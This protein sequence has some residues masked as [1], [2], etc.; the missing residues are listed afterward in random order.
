[1]YRSYKHSNARIVLSRFAMLSSLVVGLLAPVA[2]G[3]DAP[4]T[5]LSNDVIR[6]AAL[7]SIRN[8]Q[9]ALMDYR[10]IPEIPFFPYS[11]TFHTENNWTNYFDVILPQPGDAAPG[12]DANNGGLSGASVM[13]PSGKLLSLNGKAQP[14]DIVVFDRDRSQNTDP[15]FVL[16]YTG[17]EKF[18]D[19]DSRTASF[20]IYPYLTRLE[21][22]TFPPRYHRQLVEKVAQTKFPDMSSDQISALPTFV[23][24]RVPDA[25]GDQGTW[26]WLRKR[27]GD[28]PHGF[29]PSRAWRD[30]AYVVVRAKGAATVEGATGLTTALAKQTTQVGEATTVAIDK[31]SQPQTIRVVF[32]PARSSKVGQADKIGFVQVAQLIINGEPQDFGTY[33]NLAQPGDDATRMTNKKRADLLNSYTTDSHHVVDG[34]GAEFKCALAGTVTGGPLSGR[35]VAVCEQCGLHRH[36]KEKRGL[37]SPRAIF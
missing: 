21:Y 5:A 13:R 28:P 35:T 8:P 37:G 16:V 27:I 18:G 12:N 15:P 25:P 20:F 17:E 14:G 33:L 3:Q 9:T 34:A 1:M 24:K 31:Q 6:K 7:D 30:G 4:A 23:D 2:L 26:N 29:V 36:G 19:I 11:Q 32:D 22:N 10:Q